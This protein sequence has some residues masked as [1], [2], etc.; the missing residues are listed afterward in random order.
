MRNLSCI[1]PFKIKKV[2]WIKN[3]YYYDGDKVQPAK[4]PYYHA[5]LYYLQEP[6]AMTPADQTF[7]SARAKL[8]LI[9]VPHRAEKQLN[10]A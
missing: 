5:G 4:P 7:M 10:L 8:C 9:C 3:G 2:P 6:S 1:A